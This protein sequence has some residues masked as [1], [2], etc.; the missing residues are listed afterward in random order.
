[1]KS[2]L[3]NRTIFTRD[4]LEVMRGMADE[5]IDLIYLDPPFNSNHD[6][7]APIGS[8]AAGAEFKD[9]WTLSDIKEAWHGEIADTHPGLY[10]LLAATREIHGKSMMAYL[11]YMV[12]RLME[13]KRILKSG[14]SIY[15][16]CDPKASHYLKLAM[17]EI[18]GNFKSEIIWRRTGSHN[19]AERWAPLH[20][21][22]FFYTKTEEYV[23]NHPKQPYM[24]GHVEEYF[25]KS[26]EGYKTAYYG[27]VL[28][29]SG[30]RKGLSG[31]PWRGFDPT[32]KNRH[33][34]IPSKL[35]EDSGLDGTALNQRE[36]LDKLYETGLIKIKEGEAWPTYERLIRDG[37]GPAVGDI[38]AY[39]PYTEGT[40]FGREDGIDEDV[41]WIKPR[42]SERTGYPT[43]KPLGLLERIIKASSN[44]GD[45]VLDPFCG[46]ATTCVAAEK[47]NRQWIGIDISERAAEL[48]KERIHN[49]LGILLFKP[50]HR[51]DIPLDRDGERSK[52]IKHVL[53][54]M[55][56][57]KCNGCLTHF[58]FQN[59]TVDH[60]V[61]TSKGGPNTDDNLQLLCGYCN[62][63]KGNRTQEYL[64]SKVR[65]LAG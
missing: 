54:G 27:N 6:Y 7:S 29:G 16:H 53:Y 18:F 11:I 40:V 41:S 24:L 60:I 42:S 63:V 52:N 14:G 5:C 8:Q 47:L 59:F 46:C 13:M 1:M 43:Q 15:L 2:T 21:V 55:Q 9:T 30:T 50:I 39:Q 20:Q 32:S 23:W 51:Q 65:S 49:E 48:V 31:K 64:I 4:N 56:E 44:K 25:E 37:E 12:V 19:K 57:G 17:D 58:P 3:K 45:V 34:A 36:K 10:S 35:W 38:W 28:T 61:P 33:W 62:S 22:I 26:E